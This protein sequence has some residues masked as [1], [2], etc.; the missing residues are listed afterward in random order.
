MHASSI[1]HR[2][3]K[4]DNILFAENKSD[5]D[6]KIIDFGLSAAYS[7]QLMQTQVGTPSFVAPEVLNG[8]YGP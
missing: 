1:C 7:N 2:D 5:S 8:C 3:I 4:P 6:V